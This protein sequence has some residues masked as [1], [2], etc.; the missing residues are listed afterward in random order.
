M[1]YVNGMLVHSSGS[2]PFVASLMTLLAKMFPND[3]LK[4]G[5]M[6]KR[7]TTEGGFSFHSEG[8]AIDI[9]LDALEPVDLALGDIL[10]ATF[11]TNYEALKVDHVIWNGK[12]WSR[13]TMKVG[14]RIGG[15]H[16]DHVHV[17]FVKKGLE[18]DAQSATVLFTIAVHRY[19][20]SSPQ[21]AER[22][23]GRWGTAYDPKDKT[24]RQTAAARRA[25]RNDTRP[26]I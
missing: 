13:E 16:R 19:R 20:N 11:H 12:I 8:R 21:A 23:D 6:V 3:I 18:V 15:P 14:P 7:P 24:R 10:F 5:G 22:Y 1:P 25:I 17:A 2:K 9:Y 4:L 26:N